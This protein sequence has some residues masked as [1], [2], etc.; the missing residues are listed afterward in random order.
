[1]ASQKWN[2]FEEL[3]KSFID[4]PIDGS[5]DNA[6]DASSFLEAAE[7]LSTLF[8]ISHST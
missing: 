6:I 5:K 2:W 1:M 4:V 3:K 8:G 7:S